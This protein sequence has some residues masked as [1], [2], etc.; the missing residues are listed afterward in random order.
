MTHTFNDKRKCRHCP[1]LLPDQYSKGRQFCKPV[2][3]EDGT[4]QNCKDDYWSAFNKE[5]GKEFKHIALFHKHMT[6]RIESLLQLK[7][8]IVSTGLIDRFGIPLQRCLEFFKNE[9]S[10]WEYLFVKYGFQQI[11]SV[12]LKIIQH[13]RFF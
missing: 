2:V 3:L 7:G 11:D 12:T 5:H 6:K 1:K 13:G 4:V 10:Q 9:D 8:E